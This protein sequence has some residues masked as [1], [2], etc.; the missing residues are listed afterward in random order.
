MVVHLI[1]S[2]S[3]A[4]RLDIFVK[5]GGGF[6]IMQRYKQGQ[7]TIVFHYRETSFEFLSLKFET[8]VLMVVHLIDSTS[9]AIRL[10]IFVRLGGGF[11]IT[12]EFKQS[13][14]TIV[15]QYRE[16]CFEKMIEQV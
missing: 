11:I 6:M 13:R 1:D 15:C 7:F 10:H 8:T 5:L 2:T 12:L 3:V 16:I 9:V 14:F 4:I